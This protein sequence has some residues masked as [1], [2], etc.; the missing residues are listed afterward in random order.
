MERYMAQVQAL[1]YQFIEFLAEA[2]G[3]SSDALACFYDS[4]AYMQHRCKVGVIRSVSEA[5]VSFR[6]EKDCQVPTR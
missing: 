6:I 1:G 3:L 5:S 4:D 2:F